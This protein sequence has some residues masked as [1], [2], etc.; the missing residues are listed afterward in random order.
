L[1]NC[2][3]AEVEFLVLLLRHSLLRRNLATDVSSG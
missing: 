1:Y 2:C 3:Y